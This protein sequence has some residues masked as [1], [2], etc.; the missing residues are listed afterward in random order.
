VLRSGT[1]LR[2]NQA[3]AGA[4]GV[5]SPLTSLAL[6]CLSLLFLAGCGT[7][8]GGLLDPAPSSA[9]PQTSHELEVAG[10]STTLEQQLNSSGALRRTFQVAQGESGRVDD[11]VAALTPAKRVALAWTYRNLGDYNQDGQV[12][13]SDV[14][15][16]GVYLG[17]RE[18]QPGWAAAAVAD[19]NGDLQVSAQDLGPIG[20]YF[21]RQVHGYALERRPQGSLGDEGWEGVAALDL[22]SGLLPPGGG[23]LQFKLEID[24]AETGLEFAVR[25]FRRLPDGSLE[26]GPRSNTAEAEGKG[27]PLLA[28]SGL[29]A[30]AG[31]F[32]D[33]VQLTWTPAAGA[34][35]QL[36]YR[37]GGK[38]L[39]VLGPDTGAYVDLDVPD[40]LAHQYSLRAERGDELSP[41]SPSASGY[42]RERRGWPMN[43]GGQRHTGASSQPGPSQANLRWVFNSGDSFAGCSPV[44]A[45]D[46]TIYIGSSNGKAYAVRSNG[47]RKWLADVGGG[48][49]GTPA[50][51]LDGGLLVPSVDGRLYCLESAGG[52]LRWYVNFGTPL[53]GSPVSGPGGRVYLQVGSQLHA[54]SNQGKILWSR[55]ISVKRRNWACGPA[56]ANDGT[57][58]VHGTDSAGD[59]LEGWTY[60]FSPAGEQLW[61]YPSGAAWAYDRS[62]VVGPGGQIYSVGLDQLVR[63]EAEGS[64]SWSLPLAQLSSNVAV[65][66]LGDSYVNSGRI[67]AYHADQ[68]PLW[69]SGDQVSNLEHSSPALDAQGRVYVGGGLDNKVVALASNGSSL[70]QYN[71][72]SRM[73]GQPAIGPDGTLFCATADGRIFAFRNN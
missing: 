39:A 17:S 16:V 12:L 63:L 72:S 64:L 73:L 37:D 54:V 32:P 14:T 4:F 57:V 58:Y 66:A 20:Q 69:I 50:L 43:G 48:V 2:S 10:L 13:A 30:S 41:A 28:P 3:L 9:L 18:E 53:E 6:A 25:P 34:L 55:A 31:T 52:A 11:L 19:G 26:L 38:P 23:L 22:N 36:L 46:G 65:S 33:R 70:W 27:A 1:H 44:V 47:F 59:S 7:D 49:S 60:A 51:T 62:P 40:Y 61:A 29:E 68:S 42:L 35:R 71:L 45:E 67:E 56:I 21:R 5:C 24:A 8:Q 15:P